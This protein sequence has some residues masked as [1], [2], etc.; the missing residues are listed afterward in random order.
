[1]SQQSSAD[2]RGIGRA[3]AIVQP[4]FWYI[5]WVWHGGVISVSAVGRGCVFRIWVCRERIDGGGCDRAGFRAASPMAFDAD[6][7]GR[8]MGARVWTRGIGGV[9]VGNDGS[10]VVNRLVAG[11]CAADDFM[12]AT[13]D[14]TS[15]G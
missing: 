8:D 1:M 4:V 10:K 5:H 7:D 13:D 2:A 12:H 6:I 3:H 11:K 15:N 9:E 14:G